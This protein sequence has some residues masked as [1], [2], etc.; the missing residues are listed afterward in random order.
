MDRHAVFSL[1]HAAVSRR[2][3]GRLDLFFLRA[4][5]DSIFRAANASFGGISREPVS[6]R[7]A[8]DWNCLRYRFPDD[9]NAVLSL[10][11]GIGATAF[12]STRSALPHARA[13]TD[14]TIWNLTE[15]GDAACLDA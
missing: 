5:A 4:C 7:F 15:D 10:A 12:T 6:G 14:F 2:L 8:L 1:S 13:N 3:A 9:F 11:C